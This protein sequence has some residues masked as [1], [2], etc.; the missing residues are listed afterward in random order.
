ML[1]EGFFAIWTT[2]V[3]INQAWI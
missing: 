2:C 3:N 1:M